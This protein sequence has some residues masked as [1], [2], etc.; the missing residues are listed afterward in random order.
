MKAMVIGG[1]TID[2]ITSIDPADI[3]CISLKNATNS[4]LMMEQG[5]KV[6]ASRI[7][8]QIGGGAC[9]AAV[10]LARLGADV[11]ATL[12]LG[13][14]QDANRVL[15]RLIE[16]GIDT[17][18]VKKEPHAQTGKSIIVSSHD[19]NAGVFVN[20]GAN[21]TLSRHDLSDDMF[22]G[23]DLVYISTLSA[24]SAKLFPKIVEMAKTAGAFVVCNP[25]IRQIRQRKEQVLSALKYVD[26]LAINKEE[27]TALAEGYVNV[28]DGDT[29]GDDLPDLLRNGLGDKN[30][31]IHLADFVQ[32]IRGL[33]CPTLVVTNGSEGAYYAFES[34]IIFRPAVLCD[35]ESTIGA[36]DAFNATLANGLVQKQ[37]I[38]TALSMAATNASAV[39][40][41]L[42]TQSGL[43]HA[44][45]LNK[46]VLAMDSSKILSFPLK[47]GEAA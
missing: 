8:T 46:R 17:A 11:S 31:K 15:G 45:A 4:Y 42:D 27:A 12:K 6:E 24:Q 25:G 23:I 13:Q 22:D 43:M 26:L 21:T 33:G 1:A 28:S 44:D 14:D 20:R 38:Y 2:V 34:A 16:E 29:P 7:E 40:A 30:A 41:S 39:A 3:E 10:A 19:R 37:S 9:N 5:K 35:V 36:G 47:K 32:T 18:H